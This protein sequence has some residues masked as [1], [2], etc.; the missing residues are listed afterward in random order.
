M[1]NDGALLDS[2]DLGSGETLVAFS[3]KLGHAYVHGDPG[4]S[5]GV[6]GVSNGGKLTHF[7]TF[8]MTFG[9]PQKGLKGHCLAA[10]DQGGIWACDAFSGTILRYEDSFPSCFE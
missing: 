8:D 1:G 3:S 4:K 6:V 2:F 7:S 10:D 9:Q 5:I